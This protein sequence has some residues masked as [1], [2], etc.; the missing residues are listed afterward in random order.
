MWKPKAF[1]GGLCLLWND[2]YDLQI[3]EA[4]PNFIHGPANERRSGSFFEISFIFCNPKFANRRALWPKLTRLKPSNDSPWCFLGDFNEMIST[5]EKDGFRSVEPVRMNVF[6][7]FLNITGL[8]DLILHECKYTW[9][10]NPREKWR[11]EKI[12]IGCLLTS[13]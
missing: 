10:S 8:M 12:L 1:F 9:L 5:D 6:R 3:L 11:L 13:L 2:Y 7:K 4:C